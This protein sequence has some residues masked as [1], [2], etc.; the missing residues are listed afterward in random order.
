VSGRQPSGNLLSQAH[1][2]RESQQITLL[3][4]LLEACSLE[5]LQGDEGHA[6]ILADLVDRHD[7]FVI[8]VRRRPCLAQEA[9]ARP[10]FLGRFRFHDLQR[11]GAL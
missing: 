4:A 10:G 6:T 8:Q 3:E 9:L 2:L 1:D 7:V 5:A 11:N